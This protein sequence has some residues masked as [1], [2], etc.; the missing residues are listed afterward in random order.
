MISPPQLETIHIDHTLSHRILNEVLC[1]D[2]VRYTLTRKVRT[3][4]LG[5]DLHEV[6]PTSALIYVH[7]GDASINGIT[8]TMK[9]ARVTLRLT[10]IHPTTPPVQIIYTL[11]INTPPLLS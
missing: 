7:P 8:M 11:V 1:V 3:T 2:P 10:S 5:L 6:R 4:D 9:D